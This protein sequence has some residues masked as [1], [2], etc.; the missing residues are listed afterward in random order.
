MAKSKSSGRKTQDQIEKEKHFK[1]IQQKLQKMCDSHKYQYMSEIVK[2]WNTK[3]KD[4]IQ[5]CVKLGTTL[6]FHFTG[7]YGVSCETDYICLG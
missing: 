7:T 1:E 6:R 4:K 3:N 2:A 5:E